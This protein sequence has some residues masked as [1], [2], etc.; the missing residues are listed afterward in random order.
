MNDDYFMSLA[1][2]EARQAAVY[3]EVPVGAVLVLHGKVVAAGRNELISGNDPTAHAEIVALRAAA[4][5][6][7]NYRLDECELFVTIE[8]CAMCTGAILNS[9]LKRVV[10]G[11]CEPKTGAA[12]SVTNLFAQT[13]LNH[14]THVLGGVLAEESSRLMQDFFRKRRAEKREVARKCYPLRDDALRTPDNFFDNLSVYPWPPHYI[15]DLLALNGLRMHYLDEQKNQEEGSGVL[16]YL[17]LHGDT[18]WS[19]EFRHLIP[20]LLDAGHRV[21]APDLIGFGK[22]DKPKKENFHTFTRHRKILL[23]LVE[24]LDLHNIV[25]VTDMQS[26][27]LGL[28]LPMAAPY[29][30]RSLRVFE[31]ILEGSNIPLSAGYSIWQEMRSITLNAGEKDRGF[32][33]HRQSHDEDESAALVPFPNLGYR[34][35]LRAFHVME[36][37][38]KTED[39]TLISDASNK[40]WIDQSVAAA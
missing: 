22:S 36:K 4:L 32:R 13:Q 26:G 1:L 2:A 38:G 10:F 23:E 12:G 39:G 16:T 18:A 33:D 6:I 3:G 7:K 8:P 14:Q 17:C 9:R 29:R 20:Y 24:R 31:C 11:A 25:L 5:A 28:T 19:Y 30:Y 37:D 27:L 21:V 15:H 34:A 40:F 35:A